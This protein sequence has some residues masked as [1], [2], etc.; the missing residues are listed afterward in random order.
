M[1]LIDILPVVLVALYISRKHD[2]FT[3]LSIVM[4]P[5]LLVQQYTQL[6]MNMVYQKIIVNVV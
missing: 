4:Y 1:V 6:D 3:V 2:V 5:T